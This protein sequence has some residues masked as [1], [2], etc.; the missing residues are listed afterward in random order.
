M[1][2]EC[3]WSSVKLDVRNSPAS[4]LGF[5]KPNIYGVGR[6]TR[7]NLVNVMSVNSILVHCNI[8]SSYMRGTQT[9]VSYNF[10]PNATPGQ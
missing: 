8:H 10:F 7:E 9:Q 3:G 1:Y 6:H 2:L 4:V 5:T